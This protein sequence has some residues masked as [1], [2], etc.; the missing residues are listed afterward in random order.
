M[1]DIFYVLGTLTFFALMFAYVAGCARLGH[2]TDDKASSG[3]AHP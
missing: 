3:E 1:T 2:V